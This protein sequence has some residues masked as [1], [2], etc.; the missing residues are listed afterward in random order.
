MTKFHCEGVPG[1]GPH[2]EC[3]NFNKIVDNSGI[4]DDG[5]RH[6]F[7]STRQTGQIGQIGEHRN[8]FNFPLVMD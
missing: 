7:I 5:S 8:E 2:Q 3:S 1:V 6:S 4:E